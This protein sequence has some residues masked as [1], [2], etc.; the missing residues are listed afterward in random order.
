M[1]N[2]IE[3]RTSKTRPLNPVYLRCS[4]SSSHHDSQLLVAKTPIPPLLL[5]HLLQSSQSSTIF[6]HSNPDGLNRN[7]AKS[8]VVTKNHMEKVIRRYGIPPLAEVPYTL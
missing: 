5:I 7:G 6:C 1:K 8:Q 3:R 4:C 2:R